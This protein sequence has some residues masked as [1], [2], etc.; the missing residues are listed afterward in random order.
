MGEGCINEVNKEGR[1]KKGNPFVFWCSGEKQIRAM[2]EGVGSHE[3]G[4]WNVNHD[5]VKI[6]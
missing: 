4:S 6:C 5:E 1:G 2:R 3:V